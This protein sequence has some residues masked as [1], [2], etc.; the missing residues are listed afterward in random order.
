[1]YYRIV[2]ARKNNF[3]YMI[4]IEHYVLRTKLCIGIVLQCSHY[5]KI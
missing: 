5:E 3:P 4:L 2:Q 1:M